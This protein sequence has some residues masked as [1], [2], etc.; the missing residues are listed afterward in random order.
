MFAKDFY[1]NIEQDLALIQCSAIHLG[2]PSGPAT[3][4]FFSQ[5]PYLIFKGE[6][7][8][9]F[10]MH[11]DMV[12]L[13]SDGTQ[14]FCFASDSQLFFSGVESASKM[15]IEFNKIYYSVERQSLRAN[16]GIK[17]AHAEIASWL[18]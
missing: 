10:F 14:K 1:T 15:L 2:V 4:A 12:T 16:N 5:K 7:H 9:Q 13:R 3:V 11:N 8:K 17:E 18:R 6:L